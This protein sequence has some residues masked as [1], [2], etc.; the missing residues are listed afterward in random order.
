MTH[1]DGRLPVETETTTEHG[2]YEVSGGYVYFSAEPFAQTY[3][4]DIAAV[5]N[6]VI[7]V[8]ADEPIWEE[9]HA[10]EFRK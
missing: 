6:G 7:T 1:R 2:T 5:S 9:E 3:L 8:R 4:D 10:I